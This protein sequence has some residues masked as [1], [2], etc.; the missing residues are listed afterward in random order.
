MFS[1][2]KPAT[3]TRATLPPVASSGRGSASTFSIFGADIVIHGDVTAQVD[4][5]IDGKVE[6]D[7][8]CAALVQGRDSVIAGAVVADQA[9]LGG[10][11][12]GSISAGDL[13]IEATARITGDVAYD[14]IIIEQGA[15]VEG[16]FVHRTATNSMRAAPAAENAPPQGRVLDIN[17]LTA[18]GNETSL[19]ASAN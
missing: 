13:I 2:K 7:I 10:S 8:R 14:S 17:A 5:H 15:Q 4:L 3:G 18:Q 16:K 11:V 1:S 12:S 6:G 19:I 9:R